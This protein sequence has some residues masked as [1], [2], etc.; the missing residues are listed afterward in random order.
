[1]DDV[2]HKLWRRLCFEGFFQDRQQEEQPIILRLAGVAD[3]IPILV[4]LLCI[5]YGGA[6]IIAVFHPISIAVRSDLRRD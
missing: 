3:A 1:M 2:D 6:I 4:L 5:R